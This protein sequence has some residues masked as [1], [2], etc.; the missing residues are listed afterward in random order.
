MR[1]SVGSSSR[2]PNCE[3]YSF[4]PGNRTPW[5]DKNVIK[6]SEFGLDTETDEVVL[7]DEVLTPDSSRFWPADKYEVG[8]D[9]DSFE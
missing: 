9:Q 4:P 6:N 2:T 8:R 1:L 7:I 5:A 3:F